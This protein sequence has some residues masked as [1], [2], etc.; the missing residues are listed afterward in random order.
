MR[1]LPVWMVLL[2]MVLAGL[3]TGIG[4]YERGEAG[5]LPF[6]LG[7]CWCLFALASAGGVLAPLDED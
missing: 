2:L 7:V 3:L 1:H 6:A 4:W 5:Y